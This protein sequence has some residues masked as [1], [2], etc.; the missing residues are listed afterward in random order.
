MHDLLNF[1]FSET[2][3]ADWN[4]LKTEGWNFIAGNDSHISAQAL[5]D[6]KI[7]E[8]SSAAFRMLMTMAMGVSIVGV[9]TS[10]YLPASAMTIGK[11]ALDIL[12]FITAREWF[13]I[14][15]TMENLVNKSCVST[16]LTTFKAVCGSLWNGNFKD[17]ADIAKHTSKTYFKIKNHEFDRMSDKEL[18]AFAKV[19]TYETYFKG[20]WQSSMSQFIQLAARLNRTPIQTRV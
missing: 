6:E 19:M 4:I 8:V 3:S 17:S 5:T 15:R 16:A 10:L 20:F 12:V 9:I 1:K 7:S 11:V 18:E 14:S 13:V 2:A